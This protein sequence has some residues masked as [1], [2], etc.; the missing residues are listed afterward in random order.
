MKAGPTTSTAIIPI[1]RRAAIL[2][3]AAAAFG[4]RMKYAFTVD[5]KLG[6]LSSLLDPCQSGRQD[7]NEKPER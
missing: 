7:A 6:T 4:C 3:P 1:S 2:A 5:K